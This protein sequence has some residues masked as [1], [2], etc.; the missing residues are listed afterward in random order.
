MREKPMNP[1]CLFGKITKWLPPRIVIPIL[2][3]GGLAV[4][5]TIKGLQAGIDPFFIAYV[6]FIAIIIAFLLYMIEKNDR[7]TTWM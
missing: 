5:A 2:F 1:Q 3:F 4:W 7:N 6:G